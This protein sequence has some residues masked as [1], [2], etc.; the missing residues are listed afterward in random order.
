MERMSSDSEGPKRI[1]APGPAMVGVKS[2]ES[3]G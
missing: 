2:V 1:K 3:A